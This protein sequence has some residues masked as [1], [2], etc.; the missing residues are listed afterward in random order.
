MRARH[1]LLRILPLI[2]GPTVLAA[3]GRVI[4]G[5]VVDSS[6]GAP[7]TA[8]NSAVRATMIGAATGSDGRFTIVNLP[9]G[10]LPLVV[11]RIG[12]GARELV[13]RPDQTDLRIAMRSDPLQLE[14]VVVT[15]Q[16]T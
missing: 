3:Q 13:V 8:A 12:Y 6:S 14:A 11:R 5:I 4:R 2:L 1:S 9:A 15:G 7:I 10:D 16:A